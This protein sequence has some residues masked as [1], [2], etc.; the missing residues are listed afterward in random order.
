MTDILLRALVKTATNST[1]LFY[2]VEKLGDLKFELE[3]NEH[4][5]KFNK[6]KKQ[7]EI[8]KL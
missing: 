3:Y 4:I 8:I 2:A 5:V 6:E 7:Y 1:E